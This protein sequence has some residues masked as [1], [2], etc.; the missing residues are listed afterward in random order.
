[1]D[2]ARAILW[3]VRTLDAMAGWLCIVEVAMVFNRRHLLGTGCATLS[4]LQAPKL[5][6]ASHADAGKYPVKPVRVIV[7]F[8]PGG[9][10]DLMAR[11]L[12]QVLSISLG[13]QFYVENLGGAVVNI[14]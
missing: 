12:A 1:M 2:F 5:L 10:N 3:L 13:S 9:P 4:T 14:G 6:A 8:A 11:I 7:P